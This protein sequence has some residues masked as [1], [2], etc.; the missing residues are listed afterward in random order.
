VSTVSVPALP[1]YQM[2]AQNLRDQLAAAVANGWERYQEKVIANPSKGNFTILLRKD[3]ML[4]GYGSPKLGANCVWAPNTPL[5]SLGATHLR[6]QLRRATLGQEG[7]QAVAAGGSLVAASVP[8]ILPLLTTLTPTLTAAI[9][10]IGAGIAVLTAVIAGLWAAHDKRVA[11]AKAENQAINSAVSTFDQALQAVFAAANSSDA[12]QNITAAQAQQ[13]LPGILQTFWQ[14]MSQYTSAPGTADASHGGTSC[15]T[16]PTTGNPCSGMIGGHACNDSC[17]AT[18]CVGCQDL[19]PTIAA[20]MQVFQNGGGTFT[21][22]TVYS[23]KY[24]VTQRP[25]YSLTYTPPTVT[26]SA[27]ASG[28]AS[29]VETA[30]TAAG[31][32]SWAPLA[33]GAVLLLLL[34]K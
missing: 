25:G 22:C 10:L 23:S 9:P 14:K 1:L 26:A 5:H 2:G 34:L 18:C 28:V 31:L 29:Q 24:G 15:G 32:P 21:A 8:T 7:P 13:V 4:G 27:T 16:V 33:A 20:A 6:A 19:V 30:A 12:T 11:G 3:P 17:T